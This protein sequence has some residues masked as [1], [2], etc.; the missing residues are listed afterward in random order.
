MLSNG[1]YKAKYNAQGLGLVRFNLA[2]PV[3]S[4]LNTRLFS[5]AFM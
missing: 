1:W 2:V 4:K 3:T 5:L